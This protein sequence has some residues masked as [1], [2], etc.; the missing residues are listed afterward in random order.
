MKQHSRQCEV[1][2][3]VLGQTISKYFSKEKTSR[4]TSNFENKNVALKRDQQ[5]LLVSIKGKVSKWFRISWSLGWGGCLR[6]DNPSL[7][8]EELA[9]VDHF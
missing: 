8:L 5:W 1:E 7:F 2:V 6:G 4:L 9:H 3:V